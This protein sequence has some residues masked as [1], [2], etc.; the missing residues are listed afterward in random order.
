MT[1]TIYMGQ[2]DIVR[3]PDTL[4]TTLGS[5]VG[6]VLYDPHTDVFGMAHIMLPRSESET[7]AA[8]AGKYANTAIPALLTKMLT[9][10]SEAKRLRAKVAGGANMFPSIAKDKS[11]EALQVGNQNIESTLEIIRSLGIVVLGSDLGGIKGRELSIDAQ[12]GKVWVRS[13][14]A[15]PREL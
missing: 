1:K 2:L 6:L 7:T 8:Q 13:I 5:C 12:S 3:T 14:G 11:V 10:P 15:D 9:P 4:K